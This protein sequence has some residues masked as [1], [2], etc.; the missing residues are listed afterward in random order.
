M[1]LSIL[2]RSTCV[3]VLGLT[4]ASVAQATLIVT[5]DDKTIGNQQAYAST[6]LNNDLI[7]EGQATLSSV[8]VTGYSPFSDA[9]SVDAPDYILNNGAHG[10]DTQGQDTF[11]GKAAA[12]FVDGAFTVTYG[13]NTVSNPLGYDLTSIQT[14]TA[15]YDARAGQQFEVLVD[16]ASPGEN[17]VSL[18]SFASGTPSWASADINQAHRMTLQNDVGAGATPFATGVAAIRFT[19]VDNAYDGV[20]GNVWREIDVVGSAVPTPEPGTLVLLACGL[21]GLLAYA[22]RKRK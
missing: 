7:N 3:L 8:S 1:R 2:F 12:D 4:A 11:A 10:G 15:H 5:S 19:I 22:W 18:G 17:W 9:A 21:I 20:N 16:Y 6:V 13:L 14:Y